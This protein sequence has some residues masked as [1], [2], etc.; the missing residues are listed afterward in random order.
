MFWCI[1]EA[2]LSAVAFGYMAKGGV[3]FVKGQSEDVLTFLVLLVAT[4]LWLAPTGCAVWIGVSHLFCTSMVQ[5]AVGSI[6][7]ANARGAGGLQCDDP[8]AFLGLDGVDPFEYLDMTSISSNMLKLTIVWMLSQVII[9]ASALV[10][11]LVDVGTCQEWAFFSCNSYSKLQV[12]L[13][14][15]CPAL[16]LGC[17]ARVLWKFGIVGKIRTLGNLCQTEPFSAIYGTAW[18]VILAGGLVFDAFMLFS[19]APWMWRSGAILTHT[20]RALK[21]L[22]SL[23]ARAR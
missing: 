12:P 21:V 23:S 14:L 6:E 18:I 10:A 15:F 19:P 13:A 3:D 11:F 9:V 1:V 8:A 2:V 16:F 7:A 5:A 20:A 17:V 4:L 22:Y